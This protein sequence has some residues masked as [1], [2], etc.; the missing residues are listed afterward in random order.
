MSVQ[1]VPTQVIA[2]FRASAAGVAEHRN[3]GN[4]SETIAI[5]HDVVPL[6]SQLQ[7]RHNEF[8]S[9]HT[10]LHSRDYGECGWHKLRNSTCHAGPVWWF[11]RN[12][13]DLSENP[14]VYPRQ[15]QN[16]PN[17][18][19]DLS[20]STHANPKTPQTQTMIWVFS[21]QKLRPWSK[22][23]RSLVKAESEFWSELCLYHSLGFVP[24]SQKHWGRGRRMRTD[25]EHQKS[26]PQ[27]AAIFCCNCPRR[28]PNCSG[29]VIFRERKTQLYLRTLEAK[30][31]QPITSLHHVKL[32]VSSDF[33]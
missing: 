33:L 26:Q 28:Q 13:R 15:S 11:V 9:W 20:S 4:P 23:L 1:D 16:T 19:H 22:F 12:S 30:K 5:S 29:D 25:W 24:R 2:V 21:P 14:F 32:F 7:D 17:S 31:T 27:I 3:T 18:D 10:S 8:R 6:R